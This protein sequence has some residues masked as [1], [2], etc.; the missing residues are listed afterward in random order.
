M[1]STLDRP[2]VGALE[3]FERGPHVRSRR[4]CEATTPVEQPCHRQATIIVRCSWTATD[5]TPV[6][7]PVGYVCTDHRP[8]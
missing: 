1:V 7:G 4:Y 8:R 5:G 6:K 3:S 2:R